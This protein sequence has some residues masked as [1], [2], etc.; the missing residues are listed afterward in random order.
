MTARTTLLFATIAL[1]L[2]APIAQAQAQAP[3]PPPAPTQPPPP[4]PPPAAPPAGEFDFV[5]TNDDGRVS[6]SEHEVYA[7]KLFDEMDTDGNDKLT[8]T[9]IQAAEPKFSRHVFAGGNL[10]GPAELTLPQKMQRLDANQDG[11]ISQGEHANA[12]AAKF[13]KMDFNNNGE[14]SPEEFAAGG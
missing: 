1:A 14:L 4:P 6:S 13:Q 9:E 10:L 5:D 11:T 7:R 12:A 2:A 8:Q 3:A